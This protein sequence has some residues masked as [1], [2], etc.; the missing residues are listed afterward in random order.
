MAKV[1]VEYPMAPLLVK[2]NS[3][4]TTTM[5]NYEASRVEK[6]IEE[7]KFGF[8]DTW[9]KLVNSAPSLHTE[10]E[11]FIDLKVLFHESLDSNE[12]VFNILN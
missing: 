2:T 1:F 9:Q 10:F 12:K 3:Y 4:L 5:Q 6:E 7:N 11:R 8:F